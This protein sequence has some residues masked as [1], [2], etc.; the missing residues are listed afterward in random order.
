MEKENGNKI[1]CNNYNIQ[2]QNKFDLI[3]KKT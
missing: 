1:K 3:L 2:I